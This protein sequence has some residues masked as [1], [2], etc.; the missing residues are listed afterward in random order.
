VSYEIQKL[1]YPQVEAFWAAHLWPGKPESLRPMSSMLFGGG[2]D[3][4]IRNNYEPVF[5]GAFSESEL[6]GVNSGHF[7]A[8]GEFRSRGLCV[9][10]AH[11]GKG[12]GLLLL[13]R[14]L[15]YAR[16]QGARFAWSYPKEKAWKVYERAGY[17]KTERALR[18]GD[19][20][21]YAYMELSPISGS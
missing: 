20:N 15:E 18:E 16:G 12:L 19:E 8:P 11:R 2:F 9:L 7:T 21:R 5:F 1:S 4:R 13:T 6:V 14:T 10:P 3:I 17:R